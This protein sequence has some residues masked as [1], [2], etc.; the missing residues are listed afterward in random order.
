MDV[1]K[2]E[3]QQMKGKQTLMASIMV[4]SHFRS[5]GSDFRPAPLGRGIL[6]FLETGC[7]AT[8]EV[9]NTE[10]TKNTL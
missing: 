1:W 7:G 4:G 6:I 8:P 3:R 9:I 10:Q 2:C 5:S